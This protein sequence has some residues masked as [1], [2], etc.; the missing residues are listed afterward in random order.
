MGNWN[1]FEPREWAFCGVFGAAALLLPPVFHILHLGSIFLPMYLPL[2]AL[3][4]VARAFPTGLTAGVVPLLSS[5]LTGMPPLYPPTAWIMSI[6]LAVTTAL[7]AWTA[8]RFTRRN[9][10]LYLLPILAVGRI[11]NAGLHFVAALVM[12]LP[13]G[14]V[15]GFSFLAGWPG[16]VL[17]GV[18][19]PAFARAL[20]NRRPGEAEYSRS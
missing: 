17:I 20:R 12:D 10:L 9:P 7:T 14:F 5:I 19:V 4:F 2:F 3:A 11:F 6:E 1:Q 16:V 8:S 15:A 13:A 18:T